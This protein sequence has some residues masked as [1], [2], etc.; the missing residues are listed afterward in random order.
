M[1]NGINQGKMDD[2]LSVVMGELEDAS[3][4]FPAFHTP[5]E[6]YAIIKE[7]FDELWQAVMLRQSD[8]TRNHMM[9]KEAIQVAAM[10]LR[11]LHDLEEVKL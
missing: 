6:G 9:R 2:I 10:V 7:E 11:F 3:N 5:H 1:S 4:K 8:A